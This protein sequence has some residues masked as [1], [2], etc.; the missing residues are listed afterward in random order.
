[1]ENQGIQIIPFYFLADVSGSMMGEPINA[2][3]NLLPSVKEAMQQNPAVSDMIRFSLMSF[4]DDTRVE[5]PLS[6]LTD[7]PTASLPTLE[8]RGGTSFVSAL[9]K[10]R[11]EIERDFAQLKADGFLVKR[12][13]ALFL[14]DGGPSES[15]A[16]WKAAFHDLTSIK[17][18]PNIVPIGIGSCDREVMKF[19]R[20]RKDGPA[21]A[22]ALF[23]EDTPNIA[24]MI[25]EMITSLTKSII[26]SATALSSEQ[27]PEGGHAKTMFDGMKQTPGWDVELD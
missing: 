16:E 25:N 3:N 6:D 26:A 7:I 14:S 27:E 19:L 10:L 1:M 8:L 22:P 11:T 23:L 4:S 2:L 12:P 17:V 21:P 24:I 9:T 15:E 13:V 5:L 18:F 20:H